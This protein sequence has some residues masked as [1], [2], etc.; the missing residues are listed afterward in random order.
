MKSH[1]GG[2]LTL[3]K[4]KKGAVKKRKKQNTQHNNIDSLFETFAI[5]TKLSTRLKN[6]NNFSGVPRNPPCRTLGP[7]KQ[8]SAD[9]LFP[10]RS[11]KHRRGVFDC[12]CVSL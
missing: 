5:H 7:N 12:V 11:S 10:P 3:K 8:P 1:L 9:N 2:R 4:K 6:I